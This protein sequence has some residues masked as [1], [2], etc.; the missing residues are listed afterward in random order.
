MKLN[1]FI[2]SKKEELLHEGYKAVDYKN[3]HMEKIERSQ[4]G[5]YLHSFTIDT[6]Y[7]RGVSLDKEVDIYN[8]EAVKSSMDIGDSVPLVAVSFDVVKP[9]CRK[10]VSHTV[11]ARAL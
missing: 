3:A 2:E 7:F 4:W 9:R 5:G 6:D 11:Y 10:A 8:D 1:E